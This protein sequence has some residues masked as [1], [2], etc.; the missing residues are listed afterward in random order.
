M[1]S[2]IRFE[3]FTCCYNI[4]CG[5]MFWE[6]FIEGSSGLENIKSFEI[7]A[8]DFAYSCSLYVSFFLCLCFLIDFVVLIDSLLQHLNKQEIDIKFTIEHE[9]NQSIN[10][11]DLN[12]TKNL[13]N[14][15]IEFKIYRKPT[16]TPS[17]HSQNGSI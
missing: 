13:T 2:I 7:I 15:K 6:S 1:I 3:V 8:I 11:L 4:F 14:N 5:E 16:I 12:L 9:Q 17:T 10:F